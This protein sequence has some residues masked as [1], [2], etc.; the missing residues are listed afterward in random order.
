[1]PLLKNKLVMIIFVIYRI[2]KDDKTAK[3]NKSKFDDNTVCMEEFETS[4]IHQML[5]PNIE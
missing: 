1:M 4:M 5:S 3:Q 2:Y